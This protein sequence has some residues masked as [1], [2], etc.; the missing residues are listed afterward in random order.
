[1]I[2]VGSYSYPTFFDYDKDGKVDLFVGTEG[3]LNNNTEVLTSKLAYYKNT[4]TLGNTSFSLVTKDF[5]NLSTKNYNGIFPTF[6]DMTGDGI[7][8]LV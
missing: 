4:S 1:M 7:D 6:G 2:D 3:Y 8:D 5:L